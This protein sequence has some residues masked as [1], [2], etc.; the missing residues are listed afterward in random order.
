MIIHTHLDSRTGQIRVNIEG[1]RTYIYEKS[2][3]L[4][5]SM[6]K[7]AAI[8]QAIMSV[9]SVPL[10]EP[11]WSRIYCALNGSIPKRIYER[12]VLDDDKITALIELLR[13]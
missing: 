8:V 4:N 13:C 3:H 11:N 1:V 7:R 9:Q 2:W 10:L 12:I 6:S 5:G